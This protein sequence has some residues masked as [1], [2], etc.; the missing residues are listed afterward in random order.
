M[1]DKTK[2]KT[3]GCEI[4]N[5]LWETALECD[6]ESPGIQGTTTR[7]NNWIKCSNIRDFMIMAT[8]KCWEERNTE[9]L[10]PVI[11]YD[12][13]YKFASSNSWIDTKQKKH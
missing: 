12:K 1:S 8:L 11:T 10:P 4:L 13:S 7:I 5:S 3:S 9:Y 6:I 2:T